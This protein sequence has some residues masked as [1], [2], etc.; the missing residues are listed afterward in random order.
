MK[1][2]VIFLQALNATPKKLVSMDPLTAAVTPAGFPG[3]SSKIPQGILPS[4]A[5]DPNHK[6]PL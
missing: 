3:G 5:L 4:S 6:R 2:T 1:K